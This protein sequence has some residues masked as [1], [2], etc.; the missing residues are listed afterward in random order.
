M[1]FFEITVQSLGSGGVGIGSLQDGKVVFIPRTAPG[2]RVRIKITKEKSRWA[3]GE[4]VE[5]LEEGQGR[6]IPPCRRYAECSGCSLQHLEYEE[7]VRWKARFVGDALRRIGDLDIPDPE[8]VPSPQE[9]R[10]RNR[11][12]FTLRRLPGD[13]VVAGFRERLQKGRVLDLGPEC[14]LPEEPLA[15]IWRELRAGWGPNAGLLPRG[16][17]LRLS[18]R[19]GKGGGGLTIKGGQGDGNPQQLLKGVD[20][21]ASIWREGRDGIVR[22]VAGEFELSVSWGGEDI[23]MGG[24]GFTQ[25]NAGAGQALYAYVLDQVAGLE[26]RR[27]VDAYCGIGVLGRAMARRGNRVVGIDIHPLSMETDGPTAEPGNPLIEAADPSVEPADSSMEVGG[28]S[29]ETGGPSMETNTSRGSFEVVQGRVEDELG[30][31]LPADLVLLNPPRSGV[32]PSVASLLVERP[33]P[34]ILYV[35]CDPGTLGRDLKRLGGA[36]T[37][38]TVRSF[39]LFPQT[40]H[41]ETVVSL[42]RPTG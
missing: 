35:S 20:G 5:W 23:P 34:W 11:V 13:K 21:L 33:V 16:R 40:E 15:D 4:P 10:Y 26:D 22:H 31:V 2:D 38:E 18:L 14:L 6:R 36:Y 28:P 19:T 42:K 8:I 7:Q 3:L 30:H 39:D 27:I 29:M 41:V 25:V 17:E 9:L 32:D 24:A 12:T 1:P 37:V